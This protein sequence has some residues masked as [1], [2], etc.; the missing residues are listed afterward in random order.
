M[1]LRQ[2]AHDSGVDLP[3]SNVGG[4]DVKA[5][6]AGRCATRPGG[7][8]RTFQHVSDVVSGD[9]FA[10]RKWRRYQTRR[11]PVWA[12]KGRALKGVPVVPWLEV[13]S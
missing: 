3:L 12:R 9:L 7:K 11:E 13:L 10:Q 1:P 4:V 8:C 6:N 5:V 2:E